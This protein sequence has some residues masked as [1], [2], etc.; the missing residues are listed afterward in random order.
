VTFQD[1]QND[2]N[3]NEMDMSDHHLDQEEEAH[4]IVHDLHGDN[5]DYDMNQSPLP[6][7]EMKKRRG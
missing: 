3:Y 2:L 6:D 1:Q 7:F 5:I 4:D